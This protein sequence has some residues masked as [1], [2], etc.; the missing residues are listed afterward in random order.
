MVGLNAGDKSLKENYIIKPNSGGL[1]EVTW[2]GGLI[3]PA[4]SRSPQ[5]T[6]WFSE[7][8]QRI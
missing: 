4:P 8:S 2:V 3:M 5:N 7:S 6:F 1:L